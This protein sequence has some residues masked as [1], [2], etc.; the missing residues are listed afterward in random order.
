[1]LALAWCY[2]V[3]DLWDSTVGLCALTI[4]A[5]NLCCRFVRCCTLRFR[6]VMN[7]S[8]F[9][10]SYVDA[11]LAVGLSFALCN[12]RANSKAEKRKDSHPARCESFRDVSLCVLLLEA[13]LF[14][15]CVRAVEQH[16]ELRALL[17]GGR[18]VARLG[19][20]DGPRLKVANQAALRRRHAL[21]VAGDRLGST[22]HFLLGRAGNGSPAQLTLRLGSRLL[23]L[24]PEVDVG[25]VPTVG[26]NRLHLVGANLSRVDL[27]DG[28]DLARGF[29]AHFEGALA[30]VSH[31]EE[32]GLGV[33]RVAVGHRH[34][35]DLG[36]VVNGSGLLTRRDLVL[37][38]HLLRLQ[39]FGRDVA[40]DDRDGGRFGLDRVGRSGRVDVDGGNERDQV[41]EIHGG[42][43]CVWGLS[44]QPSPHS[45]REWERRLL[46]GL[47][48]A[49]LRPALCTLQS[50]Y[51]TNQKKRGGGRT[52]HLP[53]LVRL[54][55][56]SNLWRALPIGRGP[57]S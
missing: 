53:L 27:D 57:G 45:Y 26:V 4:C 10:L 49:N 13:Q 11:W 9:P 50:S 51:Q 19:Q 40:A 42:G 37:A 32:E 5:T 17:L 34:P 29:V 25:V 36:A 16:L 56:R 44:R 7:G 8:D 21:D 20:A 33:Q 1:M 52:S 54:G 47:H 3:G 12:V 18:L 22:S 14:Q 6:L 35:E 2:S 38:L 43:S 31:G 39:R 30:S 46:P 48:L 55:F 28:A 23:V 15:S 41:G 24:S